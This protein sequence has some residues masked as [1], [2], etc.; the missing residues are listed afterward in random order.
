MTRLIPLKRSSQ[1][2]RKEFGEFMEA[3]EAWYIT[4]FG[5]WLDDGQRAA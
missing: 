3:T 2:N 4:E 1:R 5:V